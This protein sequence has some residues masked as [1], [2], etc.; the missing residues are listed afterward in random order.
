MFFILVHFNAE[1]ALRLRP[2]VHMVSLCRGCR[3]HG[4][5]QALVCSA[6]NGAGAEYVEPDGF[7]IEKVCTV[8]TAR[9]PMS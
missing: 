8:S 4:L 3:K 2:G 7:R 5:R 9:Q 1:T 6:S